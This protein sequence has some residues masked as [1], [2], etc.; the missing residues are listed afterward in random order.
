MYRLKSQES[1]PSKSSN[2]NYRNIQKA[3]KSVEMR[4]VQHVDTVRLF[5]RNIQNKQKIVEHKTENESYIK[6]NY[7]IKISK[8]TLLTNYNDLREIYGIKSKYNSEIF[9]HILTLDNARTF[10]NYMS[11]KDL[12]LHSAVNIEEI[13]QENLEE[14]DKKEEIENKCENYVLTKEYFDLQQLTLDDGK[15]EIFFDKKY[16]ITHYEILEEFKLERT[17]LDVGEFR[18]FLFNHLKKNV[19][20]NDKDCWIDSNKLNFSTTGSLLLDIPITN[21][22]IS[23]LKLSSKFFSMSSLFL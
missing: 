16:D 8:E 7:N 19:G 1:T 18:D 22:F 10:M 3:Q 2:V 12:D 5:G 20:M 4:Y 15:D 13:A 17:Q 21:L 23:L 6:H 11:L 14:V 9:R